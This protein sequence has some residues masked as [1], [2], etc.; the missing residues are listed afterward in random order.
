MSR[1]AD[2]L[3]RKPHRWRGRWRAF[4]TTGYKLDGRSERQYVYGATQA[5]CQA[6]LDDVRR[7]KAAGLLA[8]QPKTLTLNAYLSDWL[9]H[10]ALEVKARTVQVY[11]AE[12]VHATRYLGR[13]KLASITPADIQKMMRAIV[14]S[15]I[16]YA[17]QERAGKTHMRSVTLTARA[18]NQAK[19]I[20][21]NALDDAVIL[22][23]IASNPARPVR[24]L[25]HEP[26]ELKVWTAEEVQRFTETTLVRAAAYH[27]LFYVALTAGLRAG[28]LIALEWADLTDDRLHV[29]RTANSD[30]EVTEP[31]SRTSDR[32]LALPSDT[33]ETLERH[34]F[35]LQ[36]EGI[37]S[38]LVFPTAAGTMASHSNL[39]RSLHAWSKA[40]GVT[41]IRVHDLRHTYA[42]M[43][44]FAGMNAVELARR[45]GHSDAS[46]TWKKYAHFF[47]RMTPRETPTL[48]QL[49]GSENGKGVQI[50]G[51]NAKV[52]PN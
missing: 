32:I 36:Q 43:A 37:T 27:A 38:P 30:G 51:T 3:G 45:L 12:L 44:I 41:I 6:K 46:F 10:K 35:A 33:L 52:A 23:L 7:Q 1:N 24:S 31:K 42:S 25:R 47:E 28:E 8:A 5:E 39:L 4:L 9:D 13:K 26:P 15:E 14:G 21:G 20:L 22:G 34:R 2:G 29:A 40:A 48:A 17:Y 18:A 11:R 19:S 50:G 49:I 16:T